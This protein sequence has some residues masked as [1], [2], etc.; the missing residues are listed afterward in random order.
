MW[1]RSRAAEYRALYEDASGRVLALRSDISELQSRLERS[2]EDLRASEDRKIEAEMKTRSLSQ[3]AVDQKAQIEALTRRG[4]EL[5]TRIFNL[6]SSI[7]ALRQQEYD[8]GRDKKVSSS[9]LNVNSPSLSSNRG[10][11]TTRDVPSLEK[12]NEK[13]H[14]EIGK[15]H[16]LLRAV[17][18]ATR[19][20]ISAKMRSRESYMELRSLSEGLNSGL[21]L[22]TA[23]D[24]E[25]AYINELITLSRQHYPDENELELRNIVENV[26]RQRH[27][28]KKTLSLSHSES[29]RENVLRQGFETILFQFSRLLDFSLT[30]LKDNEDLEFRLE[31][32]V[33][34][35]EKITELRHEQ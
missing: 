34:G 15:L 13:L 2:Q 32:V 30:T 5:Q 22:T 10:E 26:E 16:Q 31:A 20:S 8:V 19:V 29:Q 12:E 6:E 11:K 3:I 23:Y 33:E 4:E 9:T 21:N 27:N 35:M 24:T 1:L 25:E 28:I 14:R 7:V 18:V 17:S